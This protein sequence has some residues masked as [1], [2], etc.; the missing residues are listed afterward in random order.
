MLLHGERRQTWF[1][2]QGQ[3]NQ[4]RLLWIGWRWRNNEAFGRT[5]HTG[6]VSRT[7][8]P[9]VMVMVEQTMA[10]LSLQE[11]QREGFEGY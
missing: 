2:A 1:D 3:G 7:K 10:T 8:A 4:L 11:G 9:A 6:H 5:I